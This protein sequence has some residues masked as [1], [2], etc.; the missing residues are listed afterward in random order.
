MRRG[1]SYPLPA[2]VRLP[3]GGTTLALLLAFLNGGSGAGVAAAVALA[4]LTSQFG[5]NT[6]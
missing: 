5:V 1:V 4:V 3:A 2:P 6:G